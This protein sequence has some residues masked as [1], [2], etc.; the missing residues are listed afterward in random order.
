MARLAIQAF[1]VLLCVGRAVSTRAGRR[2]LAET[3]S[4]MDTS[5]T[6]AA[7]ILSQLDGISPV[8]RAQTSEQLHEILTHLD[9]QNATIVLTGGHTG[10]CSHKDRESL[11][12]LRPAGQHM[13]LL[14]APRVQQIARLCLFK[15]RQSCDFFL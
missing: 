1:L 7:V 13:R 4:L 9:G 2:G 11:P 12:I 14:S 10:H 3:V 6:R 5:D 15:L 8:Y